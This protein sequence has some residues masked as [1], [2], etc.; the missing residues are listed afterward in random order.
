[1]FF[2]DPHRRQYTVSIIA[3][4]YAK[5]SIFTVRLRH[6]SAHRI[7][8]EVCLYP[9]N[10]VKLTRIL[11]LLGDVSVGVALGKYGRL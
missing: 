4:V 2:F 6:A 5:V 3:M 11:L 10:K 9:A 7:P 8:H 1:M